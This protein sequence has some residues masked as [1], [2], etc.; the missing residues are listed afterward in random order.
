[1]TLARRC[2]DALGLPRPLIT[3]AIDDYVLGG[4]AAA[5]AVMRQVLARAR[6]EDRTDPAKTFGF[7]SEW[8][9]ATYVWSG[10]GHYAGTHCMGADPDTSVVDDRQRSWEHDNLFLAGAGSMPSMGTSNPTLTLAAL[11]FRTSRELI[12]SPDARGG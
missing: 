4:M 6:I 10:P 8:R 2:T 3:Y 1:V 12:A 5:T 11:A 7:K 9:G